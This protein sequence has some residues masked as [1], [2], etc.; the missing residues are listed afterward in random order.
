MVVRFVYTNRLYW[1]KNVLGETEKER[2]LLCYQISQS[3]SRGKF[4]VNRELCM[5]LAALMSQIHYGDFSPAKLSK[6]DLGKYFPAH[7][8]EEE[9]Q[10][11]LA[12]QLK[13]KWESLRGKSVHDCVRI[14]LTCTRRWQFF[15]ANLFKVKTPMDEDSWLA[16]S[17]EGIAV[18]DMESMSPSSFYPYDSVVTFGGCQDDFMLVVVNAGGKGAK[19]GG[20]SGRERR[21]SQ[22]T[23]V[24]GNSAGSHTD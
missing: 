8:K 12:D 10:P 7:L 15:G 21:P 2:L 24:S 1:K 14:F 20:N 4:P 23:Q 13:A 11:P 16:V 6:I 3:I 17:D 5:E 22:R 18:L 9:C 19:G